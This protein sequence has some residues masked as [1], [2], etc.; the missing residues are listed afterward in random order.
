MDA[1]VTMHPVERKPAGTPKKEKKAK[2][3]LVC[4]ECGK[5]FLSI[6][7]WAEFCSGKCRQA[8]WNREHPRGQLLFSSDDAYLIKWIMASWLIDNLDHIRSAEVQGLLE[9]LG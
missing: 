9:K 7:L 8:V 2:N 3:E 5:P 1:Y 6:R 4:K